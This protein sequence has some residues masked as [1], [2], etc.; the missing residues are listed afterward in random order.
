M[1]TSVAH[2]L[3]L[4]STATATPTTTATTTPKLA[5]S[6]FKWMLKS[7]YMQILMKETGTHK[8]L[9]NSREIEEENG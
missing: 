5:Q 6:S 3:I 7:D 9:K 2:L 8:T 4:I 1:V